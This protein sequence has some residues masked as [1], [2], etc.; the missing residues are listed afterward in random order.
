[1]FGCVKNQRTIGS[2]YHVAAVSRKNAIMNG[3]FKVSLHNLRKK[4]IEKAR[5]KSRNKY[6]LYRN[7]EKKQEQKREWERRECTED[8]VQPEWHPIFWSHFTKSRS[9]FTIPLVARTMRL[10]AAFSI[11]H[12]SYFFL[13][14]LSR[15]HLCVPLLT[16]VFSRDIYIRACVYIWPDL[17]NDKLFSRFFSHLR[18]NRALKRGHL[19][20]IWP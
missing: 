17:G 13:F 16:S 4:L 1:M 12:P 6:S 7:A 5:E 14:L 8:M 10:R 2:L 15:S 9:Y 19:S 18:K 11:P 20:A 3:H